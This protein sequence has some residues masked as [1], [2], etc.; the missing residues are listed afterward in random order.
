MIVYGAFV[1]PAT[2]TLSD[3]K[4]MGAFRGLAQSRCGGSSPRRGTSI[5]R[6]SAHSICQDCQLEQSR[7]RGK[8]NSGEI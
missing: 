5:P 2:V 4:G 8:E 3:A 6:S 1:R 7:K